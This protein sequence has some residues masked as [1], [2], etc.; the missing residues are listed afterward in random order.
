M[1]YM[2]FIFMFTHA[3]SLHFPL[4]KKGNKK[5][6][7]ENKKGHTT[8]LVTCVGYQDNGYKP[9]ML[10]LYTHLSKKKIENHVNVVPNAWLTRKMM[11]L[12]A[13]QSHNYIC[14]AYHE[15]TSVIHLYDRLLKYCQSKFL[16]LGLWG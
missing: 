7:K 16:F 2:P 1:N 9:T 8:F 10:G 13:S 15:H 5:K 12:R 14:Y 3:W 11:F 4:K 6:T